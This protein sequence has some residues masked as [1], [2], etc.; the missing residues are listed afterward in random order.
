MTLAIGTALQKGVYVIDA[1]GGEDAIGPLYLATHV[2][3]GRWALVRVLGSRHPETMPGA[4]R[5][6][7]FYET[8]KAIGQLGHPLLPAAMQG[9]EEE[10]VCYQVLPLPLGA[11]LT[12]WV[13]PKAPFSVGRSLRVIDQ[14]VDA[15]R[16]L[17]PLGG[18]G[19]R[20]TPDQLWLPEQASPLK[21]I[22]FDFPDQ[23]SDADP[24]SEGKLVYDLAGLLYFLLTGQ[25]AEATR[26]P[27][28]VDLR[29]RLPGLPPS[30]ETALQWGLRQAGQAATADLESWLALL[31]K[32]ADSPA[33]PQRSQGGS[34][35]ATSLG[36]SEPS[37]KPEIATTQVVAPAVSPAPATIATAGSTGTTNRDG[38][39]PNG[40]FPK[41]ATWALLGT[42]VVAGLSGL[43]FGLQARLQPLDSPSPARFNPNQSFPPLPDWPGDNFGSNWSSPT[44]RRR[45]QPD[46]GD[47]PPAL[48]TP[49]TNPVQPSALPTPQGVSVEL[50]QAP[51]W[52]PDDPGDAGLGEP[53]DSPVPDSLSSPNGSS[54][55]PRV[56]APAV[57]NSGGTPAPPP[58]PPIPTDPGGGPLPAAPTPPAPLQ[59]PPAPLVPSSGMEPGG[60]ST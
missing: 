40:A 3:K 13:L 43:T 8:L 19:L 39:F 31:P 11:P 18:Y 60:Q 34:A 45:F 55:D 2:P 9:F 22:G 15:L 7:T 25:R 57:D 47:T 12:R 24:V 20:L 38:A 49:R 46:Y 52:R 30:L 59:A 42:C 58:A 33:P 44:Y 5:R 17:R 51:D 23:A 29:H 53:L 21:F 16:V 4:D 41:R 36:V 14:L 56:P 1:L 32:L 54:P 50:E 10:G 26:A 37:T 35:A 6:A 28:A 27:L 48:A